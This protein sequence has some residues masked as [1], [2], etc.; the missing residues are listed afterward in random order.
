MCWTHGDIIAAKIQASFESD[1]RTLL[2]QKTYFRFLTRRKFFSTGKN[3]A[4]KTIH[5][6]SENDGKFLF[7]Q[8][9]IDEYGKIFKMKANFPNITR[10][11]TAKPMECWDWTKKWKGMKVDSLYNKN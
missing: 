3:I 1:S 4:K 10:S 11:E 5:K 6:T 2:F 9:K 8:Y 7:W